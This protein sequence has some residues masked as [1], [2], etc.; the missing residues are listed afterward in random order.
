MEEFQEK[1]KEKKRAELKTILQD[2]Q[3]VRQLVERMMGNFT[4]EGSDYYLNPLNNLNIPKTILAS[5]KLCAS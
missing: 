3:W 2:H 1:R 5:L 4:V